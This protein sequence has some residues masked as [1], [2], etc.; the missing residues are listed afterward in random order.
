[1]T[2]KVLHASGLLAFFLPSHFF[3][4]IVAKTGEL[5]I[6]LVETRMEKEEDRKKAVT[7][8][9]RSGSLPWNLKKK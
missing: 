6:F 2:R 3:L 8:K 9:P 1:M 4:K 7:D 5:K